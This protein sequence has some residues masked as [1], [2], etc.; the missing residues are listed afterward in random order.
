MMGSA[1]F[2]IIYSGVNFAHLKLYKKTKA[3]KYIIWLAIISCVF[4][5]IVLIYYEILNS[6][7]TLILLILVVLSSFLVE[8][9]YRKYSRRILKKRQVTD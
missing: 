1:L 5:F 7:K 8:W 6:P 9:I 2:L 3:N 4:S